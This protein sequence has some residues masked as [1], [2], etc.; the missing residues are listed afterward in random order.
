[1]NLK[2]DDRSQRFFDESEDAPHGRDVP[3]LDE[4]TVALA[5][6]H[7]REV[8]AE[9]ER[10]REAE[11]AAERAE[12]EALKKRQRE[13]AEAVATQRELVLAAEDVREQQRR[14]D[15]A[16]LPFHLQQQVKARMQHDRV[17][18]GSP[19]DIHGGF[20]AGSVIGSPYDI[21]GGVQCGTVQC[22]SGYQWQTADGTSRRGRRQ[23]GTG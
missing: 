12:E 5:T 11:W 17:I 7:A 4:W 16:T 13:Q 20:Q 1:M 8:A 19:Y 10:Q 14:T 18:V 21:H 22:Q 23:G 15:V 9:R 3:T 2:M 6:L